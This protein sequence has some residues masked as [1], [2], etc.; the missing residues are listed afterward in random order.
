M[1]EQ[2]AA[3]AERAAL[4]APFLTGFGAKT[5]KLLAHPAVDRRRRNGPRGGPADAIVLKRDRKEVQAAL[6]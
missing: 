1:P 6:Q 3:D 2:P 5:A 4:A